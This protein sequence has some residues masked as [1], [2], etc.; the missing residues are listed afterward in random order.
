MDLTIYLC[1]MFAMQPFGLIQLG[2]YHGRS[3]HHLKEQD[4]GS[5]DLD[6]NMDVCT[7]VWTA[8]RIN[9]DRFRH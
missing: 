3:Q 5:M 4:N 8:H 7:G 1:R 6:G 2:N 9:T